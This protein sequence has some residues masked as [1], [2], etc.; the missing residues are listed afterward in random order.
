M[1]VRHSGDLG[2]LSLG[3]NA[4]CILCF[5]GFGNMPTLKTHCNHVFHE[6][7]LISFLKTSEI[8]PQCET[9]LSPNSLQFV[10]G[11][12]FLDMHKF[13][14]ESTT[15]PEKT[16]PPIG[17][18]PKKKSSLGNNRTSLP[19]DNTSLSNRHSLIPPSGNLLPLLFA[20]NTE[21]ENKNARPQGNLSKNTPFEPLFGNKANQSNRSDSNRG[22]ANSN[23]TS[24]NN[25]KENQKGLAM[26]GVEKHVRE[27][28]EKTV[29]AQLLQMQQCIG[30][31]SEQLQQLQTSRNEPDWPTYPNL[32]DLFPR[33]RGF[34]NQNTDARDNE[35]R[36][37]SQSVSSLTSSSK[38]ASLINRWHVSFNGNSS[39][40][41]VDKFIW[42]VE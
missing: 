6:H 16:Q 5:K 32:D 38:A 13:N 20:S 31:L 37:G 24:N 40:L 7:C 33:N 19:F 23:S 4:T 27:I 9:K 3:G 39:G 8:C 21:D 11:N 14:S 42:M 34:S 18:K 36:N 30:Y 15:E 25:Q 2:L 10:N 35:N 41:P 1:A 26:A 29:G 17:T 12:D 22:D 28:V